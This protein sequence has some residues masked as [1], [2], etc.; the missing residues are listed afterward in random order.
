MVKVR[1]FKVFQ[2][3]N[4]QSLTVIKVLSISFWHLDSVDLEW[5]R[6]NQPESMWYAKGMRE[7]SLSALPIFLSYQRD[8]CFEGLWNLFTQ[9]KRSHIHLPVRLWIIDPHNRAP[10]KNS[11]HRNEVL[12]QDTTYLIQRP[13][14]QRGSPPDHGKETQ[15]AVV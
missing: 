5:K 13:C 3:L 6:Q 14:Y 2:C 12:L 11:S 1:F 15:T 10:K 9:I 4:L 7:W 8:P